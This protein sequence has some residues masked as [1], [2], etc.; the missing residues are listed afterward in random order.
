[1]GAPELLAED[2]PAEPEDAGA[3]ELVPAPPELPLP[4]AALVEPCD[5]VADMD[6]P[7]APDEALTPPADD[8]TADVAVETADVP[9]FADALAPEELEVPTAVHNAHSP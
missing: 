6:V 2:E 4:D 8:G 9:E 3:P 7:P 1:M 5:A